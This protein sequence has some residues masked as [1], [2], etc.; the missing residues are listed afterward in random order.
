MLSLYAD[1]LNIH[2]NIFLRLLHSTGSSVNQMKL[3]RFK[4]A[5]KNH[6]TKTKTATETTTNLYYMIFGMHVALFNNFFNLIINFAG[7]LPNLLCLFSHCEQALNRNKKRT[8][9][10]QTNSTETKKGSSNHHN[11]TI[12]VLMDVSQ[13]KKK[14][15]SLKF[16]K[17]NHK[18]D[19]KNHVLF[20]FI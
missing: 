15:G 18:E 5:I 6:I 2:I 4:Q 20:V 13:P 19:G 7:L 11:L 14:F 8:K 12:I 1:F 9:K 3:N 10:R 17:S 16:Q